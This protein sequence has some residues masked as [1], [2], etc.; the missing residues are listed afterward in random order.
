MFALEAPRPLRQGS[1]GVFG[2]L[3]RK[4]NH[5]SVSIS[6]VINGFVRAGM[7]NQGGGDDDCDN[8][9]YGCDDDDHDDDHD[10]DEGGAEGVEQT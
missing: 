3:P 9:H 8:N 7:A 1:S 10:D 4:I 2:C 6:K 5:D